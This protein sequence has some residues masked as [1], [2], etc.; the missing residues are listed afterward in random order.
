MSL[1][2]LFNQGTGGTST[3]WELTCPATGFS[4]SPISILLTPN[5][6][7]TG[8]PTLTASL[9]GGTFGTIPSWSNSSVSQ[10][11]TYTPGSSE[12]GSCLFTV[13]S[14]GLTNGLGTT[15]FFAPSTGLAASFSP[16][17]NTTSFHRLSE[18]FV[19]IGSLLVGTFGGTISIESAT[20]ALWQSG[21]VYAGLVAEV[22]SGFTPGQIS[23]GGSMSAWID[24]L[25][26][27][28]SLP[29]GIYTLVF[30][31][32]ATDSNGSSYT[33]EVSNYLNI[34]SDGT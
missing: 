31:I 27:V 2:I 29:I 7:F 15:V 5:G 9:S 21:S 3:A 14:A 24:F 12:V 19:E 13:S 6:T 25:P 34:I 10:T 26:S 20:W 11:V 23:P 17:S 18:L 32:N 1:L 8:T 16:L 33:K 22:V 28:Y 4:G 30:T